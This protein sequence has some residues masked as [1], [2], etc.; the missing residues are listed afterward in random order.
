[1][2]KIEIIDHCKELLLG[3]IAESKKAMLSAQEAANNEEKS[4][5]GDKYETGRA[6]GHLEKDRNA[7][8]LAKAQEELTNL[9]RIDLSIP[10]KTITTGALVQSTQG[11]LFLAIGIGSIVIGKDKIVVLSPASPLA[12]L[13]KEKRKGD[14]YIFNGQKHLI[15]GVE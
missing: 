4:S 10:H 3:R 5:A 12:Q 8:Q 7:G 13:I 2:T 15:N 9:M 1:M 14:S 6:M 11:M